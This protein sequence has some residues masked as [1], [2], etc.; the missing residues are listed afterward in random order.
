M[1]LNSVFNVWFRQRKSQKRKEENKRKNLNIISV[2]NGRNRRN[3]RNELF[4]PQ[5]KTQKFQN[6]NPPKHHSEYSN[7]L[8]RAKTNKELIKFDFIQAVIYNDGKRVKDESIMELM[9]T[10]E[11]S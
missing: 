10:L 8:C 11:Y 1:E 7:S 6:P 5:N 4:S 2:S 9:T 3:G